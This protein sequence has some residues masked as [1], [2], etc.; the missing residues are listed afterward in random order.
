MERLADAALYTGLLAAAGLAGT[1]D[2]PRLGLA[3]ACLVGL[4]RWTFHFLA[5]ATAADDDRR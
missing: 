4:V 2:D 5:E 3:T 1:G